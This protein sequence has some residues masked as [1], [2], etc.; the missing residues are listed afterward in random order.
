MSD[1]DTVWFR[2]PDLP[3]SPPYQGVRSQTPFLAAAGWSECDPPPP[4]PVDEET[5]ET[6][7]DDS[8][9]SPPKRVTRRASARD[10]DK[11]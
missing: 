10:K 1:S 3:D 6:T 8:D 5:D 7:A 9:D 4:P 2:H 11:D